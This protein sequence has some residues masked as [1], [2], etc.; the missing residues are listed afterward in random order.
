MPATSSREGFRL[1]GPAAEVT[2]GFVVPYYVAEHKRRVAVAR[3]NGDLYAVDDL[4]TYEA[5][6]L[7]AGLLE[8]TT[9]ICQ[10]HGCR[11]DLTTGEVLR[12]PAMEGL[13]THA[14]EVID[15]QIHARIA[16]RI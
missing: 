7:S 6:P 16:P 4:C 8:G 13:E 2:E 10:C 9:M 5:C 14:V 12:G 1:L 15:E 11:Y 3:V